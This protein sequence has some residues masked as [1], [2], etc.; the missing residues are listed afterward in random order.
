MLPDLSGRTI[1]EIFF[2]K[3]SSKNVQ[4]FFV[5]NCTQRQYKKAIN[6]FVS[7]KSQILHP[8]KV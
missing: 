4:T 1:L 2:R 3:N 7:S 8:F 5:E 6:S